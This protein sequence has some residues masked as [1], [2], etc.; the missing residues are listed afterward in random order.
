ML[1]K[2]TKIG[3]TI[4]PACDSVTTLVKMIK[5]GM[6]FARLNF[7]HGDHKSHAILIK[8]IRSAEEKTGIPV[9]I[10]G[11]I[12]GP[13][14]RLGGMVKECVLIKHGDILT[15]VVG[16]RSSKKEKEVLVDC[17]EEILKFL[18]KGH[19]ILIDDGNVEVKVLK[20]GKNSF[21]ALVLEGERL[22]P[23]KGLNFPDSHLD[24]P[25]ISEKDK[26]DLEFCVKQEVDAI[27][28]SF[29]TCA[30][31]I[32]DLKYLIKKFEKKYKKKEKQEIFI[33][34]K[35]ERYEA[36][37]NIDEIIDVTDGVM[38]ARGDLGLE[39]K[40][41]MVPVTQKSIIEKCNKAAKPVIV[42]TQMLD[43]MQEKK[44]PTRAEV[45]D[46][47]NAVVDHS[48]GLLLTNETAAGKHPVLTVNTMSEIILDTEKSDFDDLNLPLTHKRGES[49]DL[50]I[51]EL[52]R[53][54]AEEV[55]AKLI[56]AASITGGTGRLISHV[57]PNMP[58]LV[59]T[60]SKR[61]W[62]Q[63]S[64]SW[65]VRSFILPPV[66]TIEELV[67]R[68]V[69]YIKTKKIAKKKDLMI[70]VTGEPVG[71]AGNVNLV[72]VREIK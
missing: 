5:A 4:G 33:V 47:A 54:L 6:N 34:A 56:L 13:R 46:V 17:P 62:R 27:A 38:V 11:D 43:S 19:T 31:D 60:N 71:H 36:V 28:M 20:V 72:E 29:V 40:Q 61:S 35:I 30:Q 49:I 25:P 8:N 67:E 37:D 63:L 69:S 26:K 2:S 3:A 21:E 52:S 22:C 48:D 66:K 68:S 42:A 1:N 65:G 58:I 32:L 51:S 55:G 9:A 15:F 18:K 57:R 23:H 70:I 14:I 10:M 12:R 44:R 64:L 41:S 45:S 39:L 16:S 50:A 53:T 59:A 24:I 7:S